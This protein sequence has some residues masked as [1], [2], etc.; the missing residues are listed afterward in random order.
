MP[1]YIPCNRCHEVISAKDEP[2]P[3][4]DS[5]GHF[6]CERCTAPS[7]E[8]DRVLC[9]DCDPETRNLSVLTARRA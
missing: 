7:D 9:K 1:D 4:C 2:M 8:P 3:V 6:I 5:C